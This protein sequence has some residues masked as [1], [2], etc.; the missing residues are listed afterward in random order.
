M[1][2]CARARR[3]HVARADG[4]AAHRKI[5]WPE[6][7]PGRPEVNRSRRA[8]R[9]CA[10]RAF[11]VGA[12]E[13]LG[14]FQLKFISAASKNSGDAASSA[15]GIRHQSASTRPQLDQLE[16]RWIADL[17]P[18]RGAPQT[19]ELAKHLANFGGSNE[20][21]FDTEWILSKIISEF[22][23]PEGVRHIVGNGNRAF[24]C[25]TPPQEVR[26]V[27]HAFS[28]TGWLRAR[29]TIYAPNR[30]IGTDSH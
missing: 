29:Q 27:A 11:P 25:D 17:L 9:P 14:W 7:W 28:T 23:V 19:D 5:R 30:T 15:Q 10:R 3:R 20:V 18:R 8:K 24:E 21:A 6:I 1:K 12:P 26:Q 13:G 2:S 22:W 4:L 16:L